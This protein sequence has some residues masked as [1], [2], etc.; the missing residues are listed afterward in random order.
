[1]RCNAFWEDAHSSPGTNDYIHPDF[2]HQCEQ[3]IPNTD[4]IEPAQAENHLNKSDFCCE[5]FE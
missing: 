3:H 1:M 2:R 5:L 4:D